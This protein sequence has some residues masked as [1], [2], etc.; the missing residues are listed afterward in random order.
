MVHGG[1]ELVRRLDYDEPQAA[2][3]HEAHWNLEKGMGNADLIHTDV[4]NTDL[5]KDGQREPERA[6]A[7]ADEPRSRKDSRVIEMPSNRPGRTRR[8]ARAVGPSGSS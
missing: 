3:E 4:G 7:A 5:E 8:S 1:I 2:G 6:A